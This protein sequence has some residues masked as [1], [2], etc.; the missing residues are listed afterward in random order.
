MAAFDVEPPGHVQHAD[1]VENQQPEGADPDPI[2]VDAPLRAVR[3]EM[4]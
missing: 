3:S 2:E 4:R 1:V